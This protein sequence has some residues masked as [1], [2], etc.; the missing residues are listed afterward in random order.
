MSSTPLKVS[1]HFGAENFVRNFVQ[2][3]NK[4]FSFPCEDINFAD[5]EM[6][7]ILQYQ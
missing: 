1:D 3:R 2:M 7:K 6:V 4:I 5:Q